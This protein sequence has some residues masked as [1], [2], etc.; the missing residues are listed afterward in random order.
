MIQSM[1][2]FAEERFNHK[3]F[4]LRVSVKTLN[5]RFLDW[6]CRG[7]HIGDIENR[8]RDLCRTRIH[9][10]RVDV[11]LDFEFS[12]PGKWDLVINEKLLKKIL[13]A[14]QKS[15]EGYQSPWEFRIDNVLNIPHVFELKRKDFTEE[16]ALLIEK[17]FLSTLDILVQVRKREGGRLR[18][19]ILDHLEKVKQAVARTEGLADNQPHRMKKILQER[20][21][22]LCRDMPV[23]E[24]K[25]LEEAVFAAQKCDVSEEIERLNA[26]ISHADELLKKD[27]PVGRSLDFVFQE[28]LREANTI[29]SKAQDL[30]MVKQCL[31]IKTE[32][33]S[34]RQQVQNLE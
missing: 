9:R 29:N 30:E 16:E 12:D 28:L 13:T 15:T 25:I 31:I 32:L 18:K 2:G 23:S 4:T 20:I 6:H 27:C 17:S 8:L 10:G 26:H 21:R 14:L 3:S 34:M 22:S 5:H 7:N 33:E 11:Y 1:T 19:D 24:E